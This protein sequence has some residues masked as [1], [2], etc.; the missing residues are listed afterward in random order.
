[1]YDL[2]KTTMWVIP[3]SLERQI[4]HNKGKE[5]ISEEHMGQA[6]NT[7]LV[8]SMDHEIITCT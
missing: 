2:V 4:S 5:V 7:T 6:T 3:I 1:M 8:S